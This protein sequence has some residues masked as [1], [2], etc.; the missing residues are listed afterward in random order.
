MDERFGTRLRAFAL[1][2]SVVFGLAQALP[3]LHFVLVAHRLCAEHG[4][5][6]HVDAEHDDTRDPAAHESATRAG[7][8]DETRVVASASE[9]HVHEHCGVVVSAHSHGVSLASPLGSNVPVSSLAS[10]AGEG[11]AAHTNIAPLAYAPKRAPP[12]AAV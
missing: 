11:R 2:L 1:A 10:D 6:L 7:S 4:E 5:M 8:G 12:A 3:V 9:A